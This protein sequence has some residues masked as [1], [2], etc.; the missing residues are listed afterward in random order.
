MM[1]SAYRFRAAVWLLL[2]MGT[3]AG[4]PAQDMEREQLKQAIEEH[5]T[6][7]RAAD[8]TGDAREAARQRI[9]LAP[10]VKAVEAR[11]LYEQAAA[12]ADSAEL[13]EDEELRA[14][15]GLMELHRA[16]GNWRAA[17][18]E[19]AKIIELTAQWQQRQALLALDEEQALGQRA[20][21]QRDSV[22][23]DLAAVR[24]DAALQLEALRQ[25]QETW[26][27]ASIMVAL[28][29]ALIL[30]T[31][32]WSS[33]RS[34]KRIRADIEALRA[35][36][37]A[38][39]VQP[40]NRVR[41]RPTPPSGLPPDAAPAVEAPRPITAKEPD[42]LVLEIFRTAAPERLSTLKQARAKGDT[43]K[44]VRVVHTLK[45]QLVALD[46]DRFGPLCASLTEPGASGDRMRWNADL[47]RLEQGLQ[48]LL[49]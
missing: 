11:K 15:Q 7:I 41:E 4:V 48:Q 29:G 10:L 32:V 34:R 5:R 24:N 20:V 25:Q 19:G 38:S 6:H 21:A 35:E 18:E 46:P 36:I 26:K 27:W 13:V 43:D 40:L 8:S 16:K 31:F 42:R 33:G 2:F 14:R 23:A 45:P 12:I 47:D 30:A 1:R 17:Y 22:L 3:M 44:V 39:R 49:G 28:I 37:A 9:M